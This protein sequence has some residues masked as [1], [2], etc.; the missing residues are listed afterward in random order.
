MKGK[1][2][3]EQYFAKLP[4]VVQVRQVHIHIGL[5]IKVNPNQAISTIIIIIF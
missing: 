1:Q 4:H 2:N 5:H 3:C